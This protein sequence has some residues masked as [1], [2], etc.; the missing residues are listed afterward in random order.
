MIRIATK[1]PTVS[2]D[3]PRLPAL[4]LNAAAAGTA[5]TRSAIEPTAAGRAIAGTSSRA[6][7]ISGWTA[8]VASEASSEQAAEYRA[9]PLDLADRERDEEADRR[10]GEQR[11]DD[12]SGDRGPEAE[13]DR[14]AGPD[15]RAIAPAVGERRECRTWRR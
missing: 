6:A 13:R 10:P 5:A 3:G 9:H 2:R 15:A 12:P 14:P 8:H 1:R 11:G 7:T 4:A